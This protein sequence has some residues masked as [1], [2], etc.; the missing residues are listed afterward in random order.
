MTHP[1]LLRNHAWA[2]DREAEDPQ[3]FAR[4]AAVHAPHTLYLG[5]CDA[6]VPAN[7]VTATG[8]GEMFVHRNIANQARRLDPGFAAS[9]EYAVRAL[10]V[11]E[12][13]VCGHH[14]CGGVRAALTGGAPDAVEGWL[15]PLRLLARIHQDEL[16]PLPLDH[17]VDRLVRINVEEQIDALAQHPVVRGAWDEGRR[18]VL[19]G[20]VYD[21]HS[22]R[23]EEVARVEGPAEEA[24]RK[25]A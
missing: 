12:I 23:L 24:V 1:V 20:W 5:C 22:G 2:A 17:Q 4:A 6:R 10:G 13:A 8:I 16:S 14:Q 9:L 7:I 25:T 21:L 18:L 15:E 3:F 19:H 11:T